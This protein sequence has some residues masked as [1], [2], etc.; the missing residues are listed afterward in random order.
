MNE[1][2]EMLEADLSTNSL[3]L[4]LEETNDFYVLKRIVK[5]LGG[6]N[7]GSGD[8]GYFFS[9]ILVLFW[10][11]AISDES[12]DIFEDDPTNNIIQSFLDYKKMRVI[13]LIPD[14]KQ[15][16]EQT[17]EEF[18]AE[19]TKIRN[20][21]NYQY[22]MGAEDM[23]SRGALMIMKSMGKE[24]KDAFSKAEKGGNE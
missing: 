20:A 7:S 8:K 11:E 22:T 21:I 3:K 16:D 10:G 6:A 9:R 18:V 2:N 15:S 5:V 24:L 23:K 1:K 13:V 14:L 4:A 19:K 12:V 17:R